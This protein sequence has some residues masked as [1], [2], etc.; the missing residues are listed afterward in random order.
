M[1]Y[2]LV[3]SFVAVLFLIPRSH[4]ETGFSYQELGRLN[5]PAMSGASP[6]WFGVDF[7]KGKDYKSE[8][9]SYLKFHMRYFGEER[10][11][12]YSAPEAYL[13]TERGHTQ[14]YY[15]R[16]I[17][18]WNPHEKFW[19][20]G[21]LNAQR[22][23]NLLEEDM[24]GL[25]GIH[26]INQQELLKIDI[27]ASYVYIPQLNPG[28]KIKNGDVT[29]PNEW[30]KLPPEQVFYNGAKVPIYYELDMPEMKTIIFQPSIGGRVKMNWSERGGVS[31]YGLY[32]PENQVR[33]NAT[34]HYEQDVEEQARVRAKPFANHHWIYGAETE[35]AVGDFV[36]QVGGMAVVPERGVDPTFKFEPLKIEPVYE[37]Y[38]YGFGS[39]TYNQ[40]EFSFGLH[41]VKSFS[42]P[43]Q[44]QNLF[45][46]K[47]RWQNASGVSGNYHL[48]DY[49]SF[50]V[51]YRYDWQLQ[52][53]LWVQSVNYR[54]TKQATVTAGLEMLDSPNADSFWSSYRSNDTS[55]ARLNYIF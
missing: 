54:V 11:A 21:D 7:E 8:Y 17:L 4:A 50:D 41:Q 18:D 23:F 43:A 39:L 26:L 30:S 52:D 12:I 10:G 51:S 34:G 45:G 27:F 15:G 40:P 42:P 16:H 19:L 31:V 37:D 24:E 55:Y 28:Y 25:A 48:N 38:Y 13:R 36:A 35:Q 14:M 6:R 2:C 53:R 32:K 46:K 20:L 49:W 1:L 33:L 9:S 3:I 5:T 47:I 44:G 22:G 29:A